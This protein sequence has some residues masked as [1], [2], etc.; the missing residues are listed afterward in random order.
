MIAAFPE[1]GRY[2]YPSHV[3][4]STFDSEVVHLRHFADCQLSVAFPPGIKPG[5]DIDILIEKFPEQT[6]LGYSKCTPA[7]DFLD[8]DDSPFKR[9]QFT[10]I[11]RVYI[12]AAFQEDC[13][14]LL[15]LVQFRFVGALLYG[16]VGERHPQSLHLLP[17]RLKLGIDIKYLGSDVVPFLL[18]LCKGTV[19][20]FRQFIGV[21]EYRFDLVPDAPLQPVSPDIG[22][23]TALAVLTKLLVMDAAPA[24]II[25]G[26]PG[27]LSRAFQDMATQAAV[28]HSLE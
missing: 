16:S 20:A 22:Q 11:E 6:E 5:R 7:Q 26:C 27:F 17:E 19:N 28:A 24:R 3:L 14:L 23:V 15:Q 4:V 2:V 10:H 8:E 13:F 21:I 12:M 18:Q 25:A 9:L 1:T